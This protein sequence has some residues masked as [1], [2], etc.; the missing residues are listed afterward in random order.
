L[1]QPNNR[2]NNAKA[3]QGMENILTMA[4]DEKSSNKLYRETIILEVENN[5]RQGVC[6]N[7]K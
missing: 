2:T 4:N 3:T 7:R 1:F 5:N 6:K